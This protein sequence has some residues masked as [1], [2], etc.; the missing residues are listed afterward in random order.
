VARLLAEIGYA[1]GRFPTADSLACPAGVALST[2]QSGK[3]KAVT[4]RWSAGKDLRDALCDFA[5]DTR[6]ANP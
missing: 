1:R 6:Y 3:T 2:R 5:C 4:F